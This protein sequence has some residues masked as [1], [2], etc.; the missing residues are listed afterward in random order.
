MDIE[1]IK[2]LEE[3]KKARHSGIFNTKYTVEACLE[4]V[5]T[6]V[7][8][9]LQLALQS[10][11]STCKGTKLVP[12]KQSIGFGPA[13]AI[14]DECPDCAEGEFVKQTR[15][16]LRQCDRS[17]YLQVQHLG[18]SIWS[19]VIWKRLKKACKHIDRIETNN[20]EIKKQRD[21]FQTVC[22]KILTCANQQVEAGNVD[23]NSLT[24][25]IDASIIAAV[26][27]VIGRNTVHSIEGE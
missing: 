11:C 13:N 22:Q 6:F 20:R 16:L 10:T 8:R 19:N 5:S 9:A 7:T 2:L 17:R 4:R 1:I 12:T 24:I 25:K 21:A 18:A 27:S 23:F 3:A 26:H 14:L 15:K